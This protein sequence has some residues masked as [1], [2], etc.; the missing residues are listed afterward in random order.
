[1]SARSLNWSAILMEGAV[2]LK[3]GKL[4]LVKCL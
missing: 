3:D 4:K 2:M 1:M